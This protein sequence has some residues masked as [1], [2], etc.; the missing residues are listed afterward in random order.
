M[1]CKTCIYADISNNE[2]TIKI[3]NNIILHQNGKNNVICNYKGN[4]TMNITD[5]G[6]LCSVYKKKN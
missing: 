5:E 3:K 2:R 4:R 6:I 1:N